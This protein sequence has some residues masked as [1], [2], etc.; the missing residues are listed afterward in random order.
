MRER[1]HEPTDLM[2]AVFRLDDLAE[3]LRDDWPEQASQL[4]GISRQLKGYVKIRLAVPPPKPN[5]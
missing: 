5:T 2:D 1:D 4:R 3:W